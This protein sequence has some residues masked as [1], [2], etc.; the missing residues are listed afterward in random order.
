M[1]NRPGTEKQQALHERVIEAVIQERDQ[2]ECSEGGHADAEE[3]DREPEAGEDDA[4]VLD[5]GVREQ[6]LHVGLGRG[7]HHTVQR[8]EEP[9]GQRHEAPP[10]LGMPKQIEGDAQHAVDGRLQHHTAHERRDRRGGGR[11]RFRKPHVQGHEPRFGPEAEE[12]EQ[13]GDQRPGA[14]R[15]ARRAWHRR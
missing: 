6:P 14:A 12:C 1:Q 2:G 10:P 15:A 7:E 8:A 3:Y 5:R 13:E 4:D 9:E 11:V